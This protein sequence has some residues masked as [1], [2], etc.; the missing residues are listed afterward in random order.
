MEILQIGSNSVLTKRSEIKHRKE[1]KTPKLDYTHNRAFYE[2]ELGVCK[3]K[4]KIPAKITLQMA[5]INMMLQLRYI[6]I[7]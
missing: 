1:A 2:K 7:E 4:L 5:I 6:V 3:S